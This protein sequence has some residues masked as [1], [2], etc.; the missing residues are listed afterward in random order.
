M[1][2]TQ[3]EKKLIAQ[4][5]RLP[6]SKAQRANIWLVELLPPAIL[7]GLGILRDQA[8]YLVAAILVLVSF[9]VLRLYRQESTVRTL[10]ALC[11]KIQENN[12]SHEKE[13]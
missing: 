9:N 7:I 10:R 8:F 11:L 3:E 5:S 2:L 4:Y 1:N 6:I 12:E 13:T